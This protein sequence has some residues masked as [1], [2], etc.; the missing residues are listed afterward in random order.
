MT[1]DRFLNVLD[2]DSHRPSL[3]GVAVAA[4]LLAAWAIWLFAARVS[5]FEVSDRA[6]LEA[7]RAASF[8]RS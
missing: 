8:S 2:A 5:V 6:R 7:D 4:G 3:W 1:F